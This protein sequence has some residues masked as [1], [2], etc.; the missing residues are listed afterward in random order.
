MIR[1]AEPEEPNFDEPQGIH[2]VRI[3]H[4]DWNTSYEIPAV[5]TVKETTNGVYKLTLLYCHD[6]P[7]YWYVCDEDEVSARIELLDGSIISQG[8]FRVFDSGFAELTDDGNVLVFELEKISESLPA[9][10]DNDTQ[11]FN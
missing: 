11:C 9:H 5:V 6:D 2:I 10:K 7:V 3:S 8:R 4:D 1:I